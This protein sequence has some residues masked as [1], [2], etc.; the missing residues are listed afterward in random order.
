MGDL[1]VCGATQEIPLPNGH[2]GGIVSMWREK[3]G[4]RSHEGGSAARGTVVE[5]ADSFDTEATVPCIAF[6]KK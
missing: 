4:G 3:F 6:F 1:K 2:L 5:R